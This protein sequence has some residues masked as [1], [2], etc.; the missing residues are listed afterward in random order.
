MRFK[1]DKTNIESVSEYVAC[2]FFKECLTELSKIGISEDMLIDRA[3]DLRLVYARSYVANKL[4]SMG[5]NRRYVADFLRRSYEGVRNI[6][7]KHRYLEMTDGY[8]IFMKE[9][10]GEGCIYMFLEEDLDDLAN[11]IKSCVQQLINGEDIAIFHAIDNKITNLK[12]KK[13]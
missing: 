11:S 3:K 10:A 6:H 12:S 13:L 4:K 1:K 9:L 5:V 8:K 2:I 7:R